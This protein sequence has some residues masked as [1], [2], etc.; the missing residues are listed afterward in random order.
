[1]KIKLVAAVVLG[2]VIS[3]TYAASDVS[4]DTD[5]QKLSYSIGVDLGNN[6]KKQGIDIDV[7]SMGQG[8]EDAMTNKPLKMTEE[9]MKDSLV[10]FQKDLMKKRSQQFE[11][12]S[13]DNKSKGEVFLKENRSKQGVVALA[14]GLQY[15]VLTKGSGAKPR[16]DDTVTVEYTGKLINGKVFD[17]T[18]K[19]G[20]PATFKLDQVIPG[21]TEAL[22]LM[23]VGSTWELYVPSS[24]AYGS[25]NVGGLIGPNETLI[26]SV[27][28]ISID[29]DAATKKN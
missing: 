12:Q 29:K 26:F 7:T 17:S 2:A 24:L 4:L 19:S 14:S 1:M 6:I 11:K 25:R 27:H 10:K 21:W 18:D 22:Q 20:K 5:I 8:I 3:N 9:Q 13:D 16:K 15:K 23:P 28:L